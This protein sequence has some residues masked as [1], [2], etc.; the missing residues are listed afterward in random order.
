MNYTAEPLAIG[1]FITFVV[2]VLGISYFFARKAKSSHG[3]AGRQNP[4]GRKRIAFAGDYPSAA[5]FLGIA[6]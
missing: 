5:S 2:A 3:Y 1:I 6:E 4:L